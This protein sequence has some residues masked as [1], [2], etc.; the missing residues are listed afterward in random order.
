[1]IGQ[2]MFRLED[3]RFEQIG[4]SWLFHEYFALSLGLCATG[5]MASNGTHLGVHCSDHDSAGIHGSQVRL[6]PRFEVD[7]STGA[8]PFPATSMNQTGNAIYK[9]LQVHEVDLDPALHPGSDYYVEVQF[10]TRDD[11]AAGNLH[12]NA[13]YR[14]IAVTELEDGF[15][16]VLTGATVSAAPA[17]EAWKAN[18]PEVTLQDVLVPGDGRFIVAARVSPTVSGYHYEYAVANLTSHRSAG[19]FSVPL[20]PDAVV[21]G[22]GFH[23]VDYHSGE[24]FSG[25]DWSATIGASSI[26]WSTETYAQNQN[27]NAL[28][29]G[30]LYNFRF[31]SSVPP[32]SGDAILG[33]FRPG[34]TTEISARTLVPCA[35]SDADADSHRGG[36]DCDD[37]DPQSWETPG[38][39][40]ALVL[41]QD[42]WNGPTLGWSAPVAAGG[43]ATDYDVI[44]S[45]DPSDFVIAATCLPSCDPARLTCVDA[46]DP[47][48]GGLFGYLVRAKNACPAGSGPLGTSSSGSPRAGRTCP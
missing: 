33:L 34:V 16:I 3:G 20:P 6:G 5:C 29:F 15:D 13:S 40:R 38:E 24:P 14:P 35:G 11:A 42:P 27:A 23:D 2:N 8:F 41:S 17:I 47:L 9:R 18:D 44:R 19:S 25:T 10:I 1:V 12:N 39:A 32:A 46:Q 7:P 43:T 48:P 26:V 36:C 22:V 31:D 45:A 21:S 28:R 4:Q 30:T 37:A